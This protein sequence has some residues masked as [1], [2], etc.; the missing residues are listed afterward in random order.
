VTNAKYYKY[1]GVTITENGGG[2]DEIKNIINQGRI[3]TQQ[4]NNVLWND[5]ITKNTNIRIYKALV[6]STSMYGAES[7]R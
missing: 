7:G 4:L 2:T 1:L 6:E 5:R 3:L